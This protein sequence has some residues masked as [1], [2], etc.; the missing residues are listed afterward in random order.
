MPLLV[1]TGNPG[2][3][4]EFRALLAPVE[5]AAP[6]ELGLDLRVEEK[7]RS[8]A[9]NAALKARAFALTSGLICLA[10]DSGLEVGALG[11][12]PGILSARY[13]G[14]HLDDAGRCRLLLDQL[15]AF[16]DPAQRRARF[17]CVLVAWAPDGR[18]CQAE[19]FCEGQ[20]ALAPAGEEGFGYDPIFWV[21]EYRQT[22]AQL[23]AVVKNSISHRAQALRAL[24]PL[25]L[26]TFP[27]L[28]SP[29]S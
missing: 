2:K 5:I 19:G 11:G 15:R 28:E 17:C 22:V 23:P 1:A 3:L 25:L 6:G 26:K 18:T 24:R 21:P 16:P 13:G 7:G 4:R 8:F 14:P 9:E 27:E 20:I 29:L 12:A 10:D